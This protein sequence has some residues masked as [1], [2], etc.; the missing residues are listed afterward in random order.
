M[1]TLF[2]GDKGEKIGTERGSNCKSI[3]KVRLVFFIKT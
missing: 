3:E 2:K 1:V